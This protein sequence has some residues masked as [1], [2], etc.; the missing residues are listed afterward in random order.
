M[1]IRLTLVAGVC[2]I[3]VAIGVVIALAEPS[4]VALLLT[5]V[6]IVTIAPAVARYRSEHT[7]L[8]PL[9]WGSLTLAVMFV[10]RP[11]ALVLYQQTSYKGFDLTAQFDQVLVMATVGALAFAV[12]YRAN[13]G[14]RFARIVPVVPDDSDD[15]SVILFAVGVCFVA[16]LA[17]AEAAISIGVSPTAVFSTGFVQNPNQSS[18]YLYLAPYMPVPA[19]LL[20]FRTGLRRKQVSVVV[21]SLLVVVVMVNIIAS[22]GKRFWTLLFLSAFVLYP[23]LRFRWRVPLRF[24]IPAVLVM[25]IFVQATQ[26]RRAG[27]NRRAVKSTEPSITSSLIETTIHP[28]RSV[29]ALLLGPTIE[30]FDADDLEFQYVPQTLGYHPFSAIENLV[31]APIPR[32]LWPSKPFNSDGIL[33]KTFFG[34]HGVT[35]SSASVAFSVLGGFYYDS[36]LI[37]VAL[38]MLFIGT[39]LRVLYEYFTTHRDNEFVIVMYSLALPIIPILMRGNLAD[40]FSRALFIFAP[41]PIVALCARRTRGYQLQ[42]TRKADPA[43]AI[44]RS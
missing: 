20:L 3:A 15:N 34:E 29:K 39:L 22:S 6:A 33:D 5:G 7:M 24:G 26:D 37:G 10:V 18:A 28:A 32:Q 36:G 13:V 16:M 12:G 9:I 4:N 27:D 2:A 19:A 31:A 17:Y 11:L 44:D 23:I 38:G 25:L 43:A 1:R 42:S 8:D 35:S 14:R 30:M 21:A 40:T 41:V